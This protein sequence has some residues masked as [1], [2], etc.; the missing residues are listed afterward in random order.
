MPWSVVE[1]YE[2][3]GDVITHI[4]P[5]VTI[6]GFKTKKEATAF[7]AKCEASGPPGHPACL[8]D[9]NDNII[10]TFFGH[11]LTRDCACGAY[12]KESDPGMYI[13]KALN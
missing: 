10:A 4:I 1:V 8:T 3:G 6:D 12:P 2:D 5:T 13:H 11:S 7:L 9:E